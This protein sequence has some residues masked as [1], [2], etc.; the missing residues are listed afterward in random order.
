[1]TLCFVFSSS[2]SFINTNFIHHKIKSYL[3]VPGGPQRIHQGDI[4]R[5][6]GFSILLCFLLMSI[7]N[8][9]EKPNLF[10]M[11]F[12]ISLPVFIL[13][14]LEDFTQSISPL[15]RLLGSVFSSVLFILFFEKLIRSVG[16]NVIDE[17]LVFNFF[18]I[19]TTLLCITFI[20]QAFN[21]IDGLNGLCLITASLC[22]LSI[23]IISFDIDDYKTGNFS[24]FLIFI[25]LGVLILNFPFGKIFLGDSGAYIIGLFVASLSIVLAEKNIS[26]FVLAQI[27]IFPSYELLR[28]FI[29]RFLTNKNN[30]LKPDKKH[31]HSI[32]Y[33]FNFKFYQQKQ[34][35]ANAMSSF[36]LALLQL[37]NCLYVI[38]FYNNEKLLIFGIITFIISYELLYRY[39]VSKIGVLEI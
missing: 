31:L 25:F 9:D 13:G 36:Q 22:L 3:A 16:I 4:P 35:F 37:L 33:A 20:I 6:G 12:V 8:F 14:V 32:L 17:L 38:N 34:I 10:F 7:I 29:R 21:I 23:S 5:L 24:I 39:L 26:P 19:L 30:I 11:Y 27:L 15:I 28:T 18:A 2:I 1:M